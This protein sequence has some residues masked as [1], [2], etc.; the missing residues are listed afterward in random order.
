MS[1]R[2]L[3]AIILSAVLAGRSA[4]HAQILPV[5]PGWQLERAVLLSRHGVRSPSATNQ[6]LD[7]YASTPWPSWPVPPGYLTPRGGELM[8][9][10]GRYYRVLYGGRGLVQTDDCPA[11]GTVAGWADS[12]QRTRLSGAALLSGMYPRCRGVPLGSLEN[13]ATPDRL[14]NPRPSASCPMDP[15]ANRAAILER[16]GG[17]FT[18]VTREYSGPLTTMASVLCPAGTSASGARCVAPGTL[19]SLEVKRDGRIGIRGPVGVGSTAGEIF[20]MEAADGWPSNQVA[21]GRLSS[22]AELV[23]LM[24]L[25]R[26]DV[27]LTEKTLPIARQKGSNMLAQIVETLVD[28]HKFPGL[29]PG[30]EPVRFA[31][32]IGHQ[33]N[34]SYVESMLRLGWQIQGFQDNEATPGGALAFELYR[35]IGTGRRYV[36]LAYYAQ[37]LQQLRQAATLSLAEPPGMQAVDLPACAAWAHERS[38][39]LANFVEI[40]KAAIEPG[41]VTIRP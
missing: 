13:A 3:V 31:V 10:M 41:C 36:R 7:R 14:F 20:L 22:D 37:T 1:S 32:L 2:V 29:A 33:E 11:A 35:E 27:D 16:I 17:D 8:A 40:A 12:E 25:H 18:S 38:C 15:A 9:L 5:P 28:G 6:E 4:A 34:I 23:D 26:L 19:S 24:S 30:P 39:P 21:W